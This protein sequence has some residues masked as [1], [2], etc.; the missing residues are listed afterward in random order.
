MVCIPTDTVYGLAACVSIEEA[1]EKV[2]Q[3]KGRPKSSPMP[4]LL[5]SIKQM[6]RYASEIPLVARVLGKY[7]WPGPLTVIL[8]K[9]SILSPLVTAG[10]DTAG[11]RIPGHDVPLKLCDF[12]KDAIIGTSA[13]KSG[14]PPATT[15][16]EAI[17]QLS[18]YPVDL[19]LD[20]GPSGSYTSSTIIDCSNDP[21]KILRE[22]AISKEELFKTM[23]N[24]GVD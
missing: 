15:I 3:I 6:H 14:Q 5:R 9:S 1:V 18:G 19:F 23:E 11:F 21:P 8:K 16:E 17:N 4:V 13:N 2:F 20:G 10:L 12:T 24:R 22:G 7:Y